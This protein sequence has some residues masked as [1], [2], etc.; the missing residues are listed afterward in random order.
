MAMKRT[1]VTCGL[2]VLL[3]WPSVAQKKILTFEDAVKIAL[4]N[5][6]LLNTQRN[7]LELNQMQKMAAMAGLGPTLSASGGAVQTDGN[8]FNP[9]SGQVIHGLFNQVYGSIN[10]NW[11]IFGGLGQVNRFKQ[12]NNLVTAQTYYINRTAQDAIST[13]SS[14]YLQLLLDGELL[15]IANE[16]F[17]AL[18]KQLEQVKEQVR[19]GGRS[20][21]DEY[22]QDSQT[23][24]AE[25]RALQ[26][27]ITL[28]NDRALLTQTLLLDPTDEFDVA[29]PEW[30]VNKISAESPPIGTLLETALQSRGDYVRALK[31]EDAAKYGMYAAKANMI[32]SLSV[33]GSVYSTYNNPVGSPGVRPFEQQFR[34]DN[35]KKQY[36]IQLNIPIFGGQSNFANRTAYVQ[37]KVN[38]LNSQQTRKNAEI[39]V[40]T[41]VLRAYENFEL[42][43]QTYTVSL[44]Q[45]KAAE[46]AY[47]LESE[48]YNLG[49]TN[50]VDYANANRV[51]VQAQTDK[52]QAEYRLVFQKIL[53]EYAVGTLKLEDLQ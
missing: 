27:Q 28:I 47:S 32:P 45:L 35:L 44:G 22:N 15:R 2:L 7:N 6:V 43:K 25:I 11:N 36:G 19:L 30:D 48:R 20:P 52:A 13:V 49:V 9:Q 18:T 4:Q 14:Q 41:D 26:A 38:Y 50:F 8:N 51:L 42:Y 53:L 17:G 12:N 1:F 5:H 29:K 10:A 34:T 39:L 3:A 46:V 24:A 37:Q 21:V 33:F 16:N 40:K 31:S 23:K